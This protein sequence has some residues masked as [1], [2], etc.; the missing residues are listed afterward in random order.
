M[1]STQCSRPNVL[2]P[3]FSALDSPAADHQARHT[4]TQT[5]LMHSPDE[6]AGTG[7]R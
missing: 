4:V 6:M 7:H 3:M 2:D 5:V 1:F